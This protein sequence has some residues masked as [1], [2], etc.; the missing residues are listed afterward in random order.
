[1]DGCFANQHPGCLYPKEHEA[2]VENDN[3]AFVLHALLGILIR[4]IFLFTKLHNRG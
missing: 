3:T 1:M 2:Y 4:G